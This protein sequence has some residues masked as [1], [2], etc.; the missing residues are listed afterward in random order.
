[1]E[2]IDDG[3]VSAILRR[4]VTD[5]G[6]GDLDL[7]RYVFDQITRIPAGAAPYRAALKKAVAD[8]ADEEVVVVMDRH[9]SNRPFAEEVL[10]HLGAK[11]SAFKLRTPAV[12]DVLR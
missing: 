1:M 7:G 3:Q 6:D 5:Y 11:G 10:Y 12:V 4:I 8:I 2:I 9:P